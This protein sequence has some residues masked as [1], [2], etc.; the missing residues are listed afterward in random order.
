MPVAQHSPA[1]DVLVKAPAKRNLWQTVKWGLSNLQEETSHFKNIT[2]AGFLATCIVGYFQNLSAYQDKVA[3]LAKDDM[4][5]ATDTF[6][7]VSSK[8][9]AAI[10]LQQGLIFAFYGAVQEGSYRSDDAYLTKSARANYKAY[11]GAYSALRQDYNLLA[12][13]AEIYLDWASDNRRDPAANTSPT[14]DPLNMSMLGAYDFDCEKSMPNFAPNN[15]TISLKNSR[16]GTT[17]SIDWNSAKHNVLTT[18]YCF[19]V[20]HRGMTAA[21]QWASQSPIVQAQMDYMTN[22]K[23]MFTDRPSSQTLRLNAFMSLA[24]S[25]IEGIRYKYRPGGFYCNLPGLREA[26]SFVTQKCMPITTT[27]LTY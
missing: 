18:Q 17:V 21:L 19:D 4:A 1:G 5:A 24:M 15:S 26:I 11:I 2:F 14:T 20:T 3:T 6:K 23:D 10:S 27:S 9:S 22:R 25:E 13:K 16:T 7:E 12:R 8:L